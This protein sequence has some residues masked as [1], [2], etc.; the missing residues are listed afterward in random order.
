[1]PPYPLNPE[2]ADKDISELMRRATRNLRWMQPPT[3]PQDDSTLPYYAVRGMTNP[4]PSDEQRASDFFLNSC[5]MRFLGAG[6]MGGVLGFGFGAFMQTLNFSSSRPE[7]FPENATFRQQYRLMGIRTWKGMKSSAKN[8]AIFGCA[9]AALECIVSKIR[10]RQD[11]QNTL[12]AGCVTGAGMGAVAGPQ[13]MGL[14]CASCAAMCV[15]MEWLF[16]LTGADKD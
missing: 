7:D 16:G 5:M 13:G 6:V 14:G 8:F 15:A 1:M 10:A 2:D 11:V 3:N 4:I 12:I 9:F